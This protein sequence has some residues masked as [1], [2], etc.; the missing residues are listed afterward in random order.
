VAQI[1]EH[2]PLLH[3]DLYTRLGEHFQASAPTELDIA[4]VTSLEGLA[5]APIRVSD[6]EK[7]VGDAETISHLL[8]I[9]EAAQFCQRLE[10]SDGDSLIWSPFCAYEN[11]EQLDRLF[12]AF[13]DAT[14]REQFD[15]VKSYQGLPITG[16]AAVLQQAVGQGVLL[17]NAIDGSGGEASFA[18]LPY[19]AGP[20]QRRMEKIVLEKA[21]I[22][23]ACVRYGQHYAV[24]SIRSPAAILRK[25]M[26][27]GGLRAT[28]EAP[29]QYRTAA[30]AQIVRL[31]KAGGQYFSARLI[32]TADNVAAAALA[33]DLL[34]HGEPITSRD[35]S[36][37][38][39]L[40]TGGKYLTPL[41]TMKSHTPKAKISG[42]MIVSLADTIR[43]ERGG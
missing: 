4:T 33:I 25:L 7:E 17:A 1:D 41:M 11:P 28:T 35:D 36:D 38:R 8:A 24:H 37:Q 23:L 13:E 34:E 43:G 20:A 22:L 10:L 18:F 21:L 29:T 15:R 19:Q 2:I 3:D 42:D 40:F 26:D 16:D 30:Q 6:L 9:G 5:T 39:L 31:E 27:V 12:G 32:D 14:I